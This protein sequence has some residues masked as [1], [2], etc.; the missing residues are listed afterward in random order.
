[1]Q[2]EH[3]SSLAIQEGWPRVLNYRRLRPMKNLRNVRTK[4]VGPLRKT[5]EARHVNGHKSALVH[6]AEFAKLQRSKMLASD[7]MSAIGD[8]PS[9]DEKNLRGAQRK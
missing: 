6:E 3:L 1:M 7:H 9:F 4:V 5:I 8:L 2:D